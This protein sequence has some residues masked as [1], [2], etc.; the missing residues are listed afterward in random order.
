M[1]KFKFKYDSVKKVKNLLE[2]KVQKEIAFID[3]EIERNILEREKLIL[4]IQNNLKNRINNKISELKAVENYN[5]SLEKRIENIQKQTVI[6]K[7]RKDEK[8]KELIEKSKENKIFQTLEDN[9]L[10]IFKY[11]ENLKDESKINEIATQK[12]IRDKN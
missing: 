1:A 5:I 10:E 3:L 2:K 8:M 12:F 11:E 4:E 9:H 7:K 6:L